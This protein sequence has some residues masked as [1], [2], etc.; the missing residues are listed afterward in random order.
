MNISNIVTKLE[1]AYTG[2]ELREALLYALTS[3]NEEHHKKF[4][5]L[6]PYNAEQEDE[7]NNG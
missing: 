6:P 5:N 3:V 4:Y 1:S 2:E 7:E